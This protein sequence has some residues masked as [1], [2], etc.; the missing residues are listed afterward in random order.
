MKDDLEGLAKKLEIIPEE[1][2]MKLK[3]NYD[4]YHFTSPSP[5]LLFSIHIFFTII[6]S[7]LDCFLHLL[8]QLDFL[9]KLSSFVKL[10]IF[11]ISASLSLCILYITFFSMTNQFFFFIIE[12]FNI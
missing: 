8:N 4:G 2:L 11:L 1:A 12:F 10:F 9:K 3:E 5:L 6:F 7:P